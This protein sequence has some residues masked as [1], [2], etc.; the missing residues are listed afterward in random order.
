VYHRDRHI[1]LVQF[2]DNAAWNARMK[3]VPDARWSKSLKGWT[4]PDTP[5]NRKKCGL[6]RT[7]TFVTQVQANMLVTLPGVQTSKTALSF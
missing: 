7:D 3:K 4:I 1:I 2:E 5:E 6:L